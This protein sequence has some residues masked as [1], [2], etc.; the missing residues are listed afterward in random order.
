MLPFLTVYDPL[1]GSSGSIDPLGALQTYV[2]LADLLLPGV[3]TITTRSRYLSMLCAAIAGAEKY[4]QILPG[5]SGL[6]QR[7]KAVEPFERIWAL[8]CVA[9]REAGHQG[10]A[11]GLRGITYAEK[12][13][14]D[15]ATSG[16]KVNC[17]FRLLKFQSRTGAVGT[18]WTSLVG[19]ELVHAD[20]GSLADEGLELAEQFP[21]LPLESKDKGRFAD[22]EIAHRVSM[23]LDDLIAWSEKCHMQAAGHQ[24]RRQLGEALTADDRRECVSRALAQMTG[25]IPDLW[26]TSALARLRMLLTKLP[27]AV[28]LGLP[29]VIDAIVV[30]EHFH[31]A[32]L[33]VFETLLWWGT[34]NAGK[35]VADLVVDRD[36][37]KAADRCRETA[38]VL[39]GFRESCERLDVRDAVDGLAGWSFQV[40]RCRSERE[41]V[42]EL[43][44][45]HHRVQ[46]GKMDGGMPKRD[47]IASDSSTLLRPS[48]RFQRNDRPS[49]AVGKSLTHPYRL[50]PFV[51]MLRENRVIHKGS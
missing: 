35:P 5:A 16:K 30:T 25:E 40:E 14:R 50:E 12:S 11:D 32:V 15:F 23:S 22:P 36:F 33:A 49:R 8:A 9:A 46:S 7:R 37:R 48:P 41:L 45:R 26:E 3:T 51:Y 17:D 4:R 13:Y 43:L 31:E 10:A 1:G 47:W 28:E 24:E 2:T 42:T 44:D 18:Y 19:G 34:Q 29:V 6:A 39:W 21:E 20:T 38:K 27:R